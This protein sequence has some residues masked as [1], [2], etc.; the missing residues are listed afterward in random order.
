M[1]SILWTLAMVAFLVFAATDFAGLAVSPTLVVPGI[2]EIRSGQTA[3]AGLDVDQRNWTG[4]SWGTSSALTYEST[5]GHPDGYL[6]MALFA[7]G[8]Q[9]YWIQPFR[10]EGKTP[11]TTAVRLDIEVVGGLVEGYLFVTIDSSPSNPDSNTAIAA[12]PFT[13]PTSWSSFGPFRNDTRVIDAGLYYLKVAFVANATSGPVEVGLDNV[14][15][16][17]ATDAGIVFYLPAPFP[18]RVF[19]SQDKALFLSYYGLIVATIFLIGGYYVFRERRETWN[20]FRAPI[21]AIGTRLRARSTWIAVAQVWMAVTFF[22]FA[23]ILFIPL[24]GI[25][26][27]TPINI[28]SRNAWSLLFD[29]ANAGVYEELIFRLLLIGAPMALASVAFRFLEVNRGTA[30]RLPGSAGRHLAGAWRYLFGGV[31]RRDSPKEA[32]VAAWVLLFGSAAIFGL[33]HVPGWGWWKS[34][35]TFVAGL[36]FGYLFL[37]HGVGAAILAHFVNDYALALFYEGIGGQA[38]ELFISLL[39]IGLVIAGAGF[40]AWYSIDA[41][42]HLTVLIG[43]F[44]PPRRVRPASRPLAPLGTPPPALDPARAPGP[45]PTPRPASPDP[46]FGTWSA[47][48]S[49]QAAPNAIR[50]P[51]RIPRDYAPSYAPPPYGYPPVRFQCPSCARLSGRIG[52]R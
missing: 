31:L 30:G 37:R 12:V 39:F 7:S 19:A 28:D 40:F 10:V 45:L 13:G 1:L 11:F 51:G 6:K 44:R 27:T 49:F 17:W 46:A 52:C 48:P 32:H 14:R 50:D 16:S 36:G 5:G 18:V 33:A 9:G 21:E 41:V 15:L 4:N 23:V 24:I 25:E 3:N 34:V 42:R 8:S 2:Q 29:L 38:L 35:P 22:Q 47:A 20:A 26:P 43:Q